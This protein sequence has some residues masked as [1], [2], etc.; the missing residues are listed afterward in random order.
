MKMIGLLIKV[1]HFYYNNNLAV[2]NTSV[3]LY[4]KVVTKCMIVMGN[5][6]SH[7]PTKESYN[8]AAFVSKQLSNFMNIFQNHAL[9]IP[10]KDM[11]T[12]LNAFMNFYDRVGKA[13][14]Q[15]ELDIKK[16]NFDSNRSAADPYL[17]VLAVLQHKIRKI[18]ILHLK[19]TQLQSKWVIML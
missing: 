19:L 18:T 9:K 17:Q 4:K 1:C 15:S 11:E 10:I 5:S 8:V 12:L 14:N 13:P 6:M 2:N 16:K 7:C 3:Q